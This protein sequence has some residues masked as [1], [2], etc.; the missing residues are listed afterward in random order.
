MNSVLFKHRT[1][2]LNIFTTQYHIRKTIWLTKHRIHIFHIK[3]FR[4]KHAQQM[5]KSAGP[6]RDTD[7]K[8]RSAI[9]NKTVLPENFSI[10]APAMTGPRNI[11]S[12]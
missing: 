9:Q 12:P 8:N 6:V 11:P 1:D 7:T 2:F 3:I 5:S 4:S 10:T